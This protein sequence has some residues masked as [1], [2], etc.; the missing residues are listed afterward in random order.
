MESLSYAF[1]DGIS[2]ARRNVVKVIRVPQILVAVLGTP[3]IMVLMFA[4][5]FGGSIDLP[6]GS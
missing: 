4:Y 2:I 5:V 3:I 6:G 1:A